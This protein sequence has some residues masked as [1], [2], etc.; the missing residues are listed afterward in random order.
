MVYRFVYGAEGK[1]QQRGLL[2]LPGAGGTAPQRREK[3]A[4]LLS[5]EGKK[6][7]AG[8]VLR[9]AVVSRRSLV[10]AFTAVGWQKKAW[11]VCASRRQGTA[12]SRA[13]HAQA[14]CGVRRSRVVPTTTPEAGTA[15]AVQPNA[16]T[17]LPRRHAHAT[18]CRCARERAVMPRMSRRAA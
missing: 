12:R 9:Y 16:E 8:E 3:R 17:P 2:G 15:E 13:S 14:E 6:R 4:S 10:E 11:R 5:T 18:R 1:R 7:I